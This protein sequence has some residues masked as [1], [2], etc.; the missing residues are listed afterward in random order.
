MDSWLFIS[1]T[2]K[3]ETF[4]DMLKQGQIQTKSWLKSLTPPTHL[5]NTRILKKLIIAMC[6][7]Y[8]LDLNPNSYEVGIK[9]K[10]TR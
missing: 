3:A 8:S 7:L 10:H 5:G 1:H 2:Q 4:L 9:L 6:P